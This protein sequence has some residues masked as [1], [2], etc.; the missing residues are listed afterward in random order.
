M[1]SWSCSVLPRRMDGIHS[2]Q[3]SSDLLSASIF[4]IFLFFLFFF[5]NRRGNASSV[6]YFL[7]LTRRW[8]FRFCDQICGEVLPLFDSC[9]RSEI[10]AV[11]D[12]SY[13]VGTIIGMYSDVSG[14]ND[15]G[16][17]S[18]CQF[19]LVNWIT[20]LFYFSNKIS[21]TLKHIFIKWCR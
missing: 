6:G 2:T 7:F 4:R 11:M 12:L 16:K 13:S 8:D 14:R 17:T 5:K 3:G 18:V 10:I 19:Y 20:F 21:I 15:I 1:I 9:L